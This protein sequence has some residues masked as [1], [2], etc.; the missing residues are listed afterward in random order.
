MSTNILNIYSEFQ[1]NTQKKQ[2]DIKYMALGLGGEVGEVQN[3][4]KKLERDDNNQLDE[5]RRN[6]IITE[7]GDT[8]WYFTG[9]CNQIGCSLQ[10]ILENNME[11]ILQRNQ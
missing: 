3:E 6:K 10:Q 5:D 11:K 2:F 7:L 8:M 1:Q 4:I 9:I